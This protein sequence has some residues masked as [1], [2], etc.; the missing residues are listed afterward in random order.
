M[1]EKIHLKLK[2][3]HFLAFTDFYKTGFNYRSEISSTSSSG[4]EL[5]E[6]DAQV[7]PKMSA[8]P[9]PLDQ[10]V[11]SDYFMKYHQ[12]LWLR[13]YSGCFHLQTS[14]VRIPSSA[15]KFLTNYHQLYNRKDENK[16][17]ESRNGPSLKTPTIGVSL[18][19]P[20]N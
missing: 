14:A 7:F 15:K 20:L 16:E 19:I 6:I 17:K 13:W 5:E 3:R 2:F 4:T 9:G 1:F 11:F 18:L 10:V 8:C 12:W